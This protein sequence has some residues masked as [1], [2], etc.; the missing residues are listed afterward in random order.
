MAEDKVRA[1]LAL[2]QQAGCMD[3]VKPEVLVAARPAR[4]ASAGGFGMFASARCFL[5]AAGE[6]GQE[7]SGRAKAARRALGRAGVGWGEGGFGC[8]GDCLG[9]GA[10]SCSEGERRARPSAPPRDWEAG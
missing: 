7:G 8:R 10:P 9:G 3:L 6:T 2:L 4:R 5:S 1:A